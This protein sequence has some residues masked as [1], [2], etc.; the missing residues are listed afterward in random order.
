MK[1][2]KKIFA[3][4]V[5]LVI[6]IGVSYYT[7]SQRDEKKEIIIEDDTAPV[8]EYINDRG[9]KWTV[10]EGR[11]EFQVSSAEV[12]PR[13]VSGVI[14]P[15][16]V[17]VGD[18]QIME[19]T[20]HGDVPL[21]RVW[22]E[23]ETDK[24]IEIV[25]LTLIETKVLA[26]EWFEGQDYLI[27]SDGELIINNTSLAWFTV[28]NSIVKRAQAQGVVQY[29]YKG[30]WTVRDT[31]TKTYRTKFVAQ[32][33]Q[34]R[35]DEMTLAW[36]DPVCDFDE[37]GLLQSNCTITDGVDGVDNTN[38]GFAFSALTINLTG[39]ILAFNP[40]KAFDIDFAGRVVLGG[41]A[42]QQTYLYYADVDG[43]RYSPVVDISTNSSAGP[44]SQK[45]RVYLTFRPVSENIDCYD[46][47][48]NA[49]PGQTAWFTVHRG[50][51][52]FDYNCDGNSEF[53]YGTV[54]TGSC[55]NWPGP[56][57]LW[58]LRI[59]IT[60]YTKVCDCTWCSVKFNAYADW[61]YHCGDEDGDNNAC[62]ENFTTTITPSSGPSSRR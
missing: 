60:D 51:G 1:N 22:A 47:N 24:D 54:I 17:K 44:L 20:V 62:D 15:L 27:N 42:I 26:R 32:D 11:Y 45:T 58:G 9:E 46:S 40:T 28:L 35:T 29:L 2:N 25:D 6:I 3:W 52:S 55:Y 50:D 21:T 23:I 5:I 61:D 41:G 10:P 39:G 43:D 16:D 36:S 4:G 18:V 13:L 53:R 33:E 49:R 59:S 38:M 19:I 12:Y 48:A 37:N 14:D 30:E 31:H 7:L 57:Q 34:G 8:A 56:S